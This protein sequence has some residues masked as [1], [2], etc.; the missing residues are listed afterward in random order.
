MQF[1][2]HPMTPYIAIATP[3]FSVCIVGFFLWLKMPAQE[4]VD[5][6]PN[7]LPEPP[8]EIPNGLEVMKEALQ[9]RLPPDFVAARKQKLAQRQ[10]AL[11]PKKPFS[12][13]Q[14]QRRFPTASDNYW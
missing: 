4:T 6:T 11:Q 7:T 10:T 1:L 8:E 3:L 14:K 2:N 13:H 9:G 5:E 12:V